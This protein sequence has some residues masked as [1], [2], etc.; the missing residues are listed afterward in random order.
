MKLL[1]EPLV[2]DESDCPYISG[3]KWRFSYFFAT[4]VNAEELNYILS[5][6]WRK[7]GIYYFRPVCRD[8]RDCI[9]IRI[10]TSDFS[11]S[12]SQKRVLKKCSGIQV[13]FRELEY[14]DEIYELYRL[15]SESRFDKVANR[16]DFCNSF[17]MPSCPARQ[18]EYYIDNR[19][20]A[21][22]F[23]D[24]STEAVSSVY[25]IYHP[26]ILRFSPGTFSVLREIS[27]AGSLGLKYY[28]LGY[29]INCNSR[30]SYK[31]SFHKNQK[32]NWLTGIWSD[33]DEFSNIPPTI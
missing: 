31:N 21:V 5:R 32:M 20:M 2:S 30:M 12:K 27:Y 17:Y 29:Y 33:E 23:L 19:L 13:E 1:S 26:D 18:S 16:D 22:G 24:V 28:Y 7:F 25:F 10:E 8:C 3:K 11:P 4:D 6:G 14:R 15:H 9:P